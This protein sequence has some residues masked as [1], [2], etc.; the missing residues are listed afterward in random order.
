[1]TP[2]EF[3]AA[4][5]ATGSCGRFSDCERLQFRRGAA[6]DDTACG[7]AFAMVEQAL[8]ERGQTPQAVAHFINRLIFCMFAADVGLLPDHRMD[9][10]SARLRG[11]SSLRPGSWGAQCA[12]QPRGLGRY[13]KGLNA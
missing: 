8:R 5:A 6:I 7:R 13:H 3:I 11:G 9:G 4:A 1:M 10:G 12:V 2:Y